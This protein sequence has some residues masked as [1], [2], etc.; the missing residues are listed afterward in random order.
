VS[1]IELHEAGK[2]RG[3]EV[4][5]ETTRGMPERQW[6]QGSEEHGERLLL[7]DRKGDKTKLREA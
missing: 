6:C 4:G 2:W 7:L 5:R 1:E 3:G